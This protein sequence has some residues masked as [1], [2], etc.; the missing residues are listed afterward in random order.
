MELAYST[1]HEGSRGPMTSAAAPLSRDFVAIFFQYLLN[2]QKWHSSKTT[3][4]QLTLPYK[5]A[6]RLLT[7][8]MDQLKIW[9]NKL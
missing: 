9:L 6:F 2:V 1:H 5:K 8:L 7:Q 4:L 3:T